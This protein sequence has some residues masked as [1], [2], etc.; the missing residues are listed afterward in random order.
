MSRNPRLT[1]Q[2]GGQIVVA[3]TPSADIKSK[4]LWNIPYTESGWHI[5]MSN[6]DIV[7]DIYIQETNDESLAEANWVNVVFAD[8]TTK[9]PVSSGVAINAFRH[10]VSFAKHLRVFFDWTSGSTGQLDAYVTKA[11]EK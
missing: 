3:E 9:I 11:T 4:A 2:R 6:T 7:G 1:Q 5:I 8:G 10:V